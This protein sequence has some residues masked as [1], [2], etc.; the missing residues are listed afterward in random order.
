MP[1]EEFLKSSKRHVFSLSMVG[2]V[3]FPPDSHFA[4][5][6][7]SHLLLPVLGQ[8]TADDV[9]NVGLLFT[10]ETASLCGFEGGVDGVLGCRTLRRGLIMG[11]GGGEW[12]HSKL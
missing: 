7:N 3:S 1:D 12:A 10:T 2:C 6:P 4:H 11:V 9:Q 5:A 8:R